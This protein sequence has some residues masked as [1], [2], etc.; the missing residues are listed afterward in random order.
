MRPDP[1]PAVTSGRRLPCP[2]CHRRP[3]SRRVVNAVQQ[4]GFSIVIAVFILVVMS[5]LAATM[6]RVQEADTAGT[7]QDT[8][9]VR[10]FYAAESGA[11][12]AMNR[13]YLDG[14]GC[15]GIGLPNG[16]AAWDETFLA[17]CRLSSLSCQAETV[18]G[19]T[20]YQ[21]R[22]TG[23]CRSGAGDQFVASRTVEVRARP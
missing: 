18:S 5:L 20:F 8:L 9:T 10:A 7:A 17:Q 15:A 1:V 16:A 12:F 11:Q 22:S 21:L 3:A 14:V 19:M 2:G 23:E 4:R 13:L 6:L